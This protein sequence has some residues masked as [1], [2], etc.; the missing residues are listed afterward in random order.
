[1]NKL[2]LKKETLQLLQ[3]SQAGEVQGGRPNQLDTYESCRCIT[4]GGGKTCDC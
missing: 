2:V 3:T 1:M 4:V